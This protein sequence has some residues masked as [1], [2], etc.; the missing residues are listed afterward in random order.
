MTTRLITCEGPAPFDLDALGTYLSAH[1]EGFAGPLVLSRFAGGQSNPTFKL[2]GS[3]RSYV[4]RT[5]PAPA[6]LLLKSAHAVDR[7]FRIQSALAA[8]DVPVAKM[9]CLCEDEGVIGRAFY[10]MELLDGRIFWDPALPGQ[11]PAER[12]AIF[13]EMNRVIAALHAVDPTAVGLS[14]YGRPGNYFGRQISRWSRQYLDSKTEDMPVMERLIDWLPAHIPV[15]DPEPLSIVHG[16]YRID[17]LVFHPTEARVI[18][19]LDWELSTLGHPLGDFAYNCMTWHVLPTVF[20]GIA[21]LDLAALGIPDADQYV[22]RYLQRTGRVLAGDW[23]FYLAYNMFRMASILQGIKKRAVD[24]IAASSEA[25]QAAAA[26]RSL[27]ELAW[28]YASKVA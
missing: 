15:E 9:Y 12:G 14:D 5:K 1:V 26:T 11:T 13:D 28:T 17:N 6:H 24:G 10:L 23:N 2:A 25:M 8:T 21:G 22:A 16:D 7:E 3:S 27:A 19:I 20:R 4:L 18:G